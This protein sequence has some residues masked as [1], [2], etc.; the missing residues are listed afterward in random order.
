MHKD[1]RHPDPKQK[2]SKKKKEEEADDNEYG[3]QD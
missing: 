3:G 2:K 1:I